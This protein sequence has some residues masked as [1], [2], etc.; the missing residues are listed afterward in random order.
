MCI[1]V[2]WWLNISFVEMFTTDSKKVVEQLVLQLNETSD[3]RVIIFG[4]N[5]TAIEARELH[6][7]ILN[8]FAKHGSLVY[9]NEG[10]NDGCVPDNIEHHLAL[11]D[12]RLKLLDLIVTSLVQADTQS[13]YTPDAFVE[14]R[15][16]KEKGV[17]PKEAVYVLKLR[18]YAFP[19]ISVN[20]YKNDTLRKA[21]FPDLSDRE[22]ILLIEETERRIDT[23][24]KLSK[25]LSVYR[26]IPLKEKDKI[27]IFTRIVEC[28][29][30]VSDRL[31]TI[32]IGSIRHTLSVGLS[33]TEE[34]AFFGEKLKQYLDG[35]QT[36]GHPMYVMRSWR[37]LYMAKR[38][39]AAREA[40]SPLNVIVRLGELHILD[41]AQMGVIG[42]LTLLRAQEPP[43]EATVLHLS[44][45]HFVQFSP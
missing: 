31:K 8:Q 13:D 45:G 32:Y 23:L 19:Q 18:L 11:E 7:V 21:C 16:N 28:L 12:Q 10:L 36:V 15:K 14:G 33:P 41:N 27:A 20:L 43:L 42:I 2:C 22:A 9:L 24:L 37:N 6:H 40:Y 35:N 39:I 44:D 4:E 34:D 17:L 26:D 25:G 5:H 3:S 29:H 1:V 38:I 30:E